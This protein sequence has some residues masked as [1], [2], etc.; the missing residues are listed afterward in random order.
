MNL[1]GWGTEEEGIQPINYCVR[2]GLIS[3]RLG[4]VGYLRVGVL[5]V[6]LWFLNIGRQGGGIGVRQMECEEL[7]V[8]EKADERSKEGELF[9][10]EEEEETTMV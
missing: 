3:V 10:I 6:I 7:E 4:V 8:Q 5:Q 1:N 9:P 2:V